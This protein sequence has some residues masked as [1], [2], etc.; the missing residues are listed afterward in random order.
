MKLCSYC[1]KRIKRN[2]RYITKYQVYFHPF[3]W[4][5]LDLY[6]KNAFSII[7]ELVESKRKGKKSPYP[8]PKTSYYKMG[9]YKGDDKN[10]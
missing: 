1:D 2:E 6:F 4:E 7:D 5:I 3:C 8:K 9:D 10:K